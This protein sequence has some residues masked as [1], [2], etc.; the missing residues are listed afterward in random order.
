MII[1]IL[2][3]DLFAQTAK[4]WD[5]TYVACGYIGTSIC[6]LLYT[7]LN[8]KYPLLKAICTTLFISLTKEFCD[9]IYKLT[10]R[11]EHNF[12]DRL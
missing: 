11:K 10:G 7:K 2:T 12:W 8:L 1:L 9:E 3:G 6:D 5:C 4:S